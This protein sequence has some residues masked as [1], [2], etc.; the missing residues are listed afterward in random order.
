MPTTNLGEM[1]AL[2]AIT[3]DFRCLSPSQSVKSPCHRAE[4]IG[5]VSEGTNFN[6]ELLRMQI[7]LV[8]AAK[9]AKAAAALDYRH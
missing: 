5:R 9:A 3:M 7:P 6:R 8:T 4:F 2:L 1:Q